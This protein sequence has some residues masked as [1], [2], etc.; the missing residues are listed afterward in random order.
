MMKMLMMKEVMEQVKM[1]YSFCA[2]MV[3]NSDDM[4]VEAADD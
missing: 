2:N 1:V 3:K 4:N